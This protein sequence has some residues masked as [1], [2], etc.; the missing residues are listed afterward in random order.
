MIR[1]RE[2]SGDW[3]GLLPS[4]APRPAQRAEP[5][6]A[7]LA[8]RGQVVLEDRAESAPFFEVEAGHG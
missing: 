4:F 5:S 8:W 2:T 7:Y 6:A 3:P 1:N